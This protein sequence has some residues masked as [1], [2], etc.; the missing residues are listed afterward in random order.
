[1]S[2]FYT[3]LVCWKKTNKQKHTNSAFAAQGVMSGV[4][5]CVIAMG[6]ETMTNV[7]IGANIIDSYKAGRGQPSESKGIQ[8]KRPGV[9]FSQF[10]GAELL[11]AKYSLTREE[12]DKFAVESH[13]KATEATKAGKFKQEILPLQGKNK[14]G[15]VVVHDKDEG[16]RP[17]TNLESLSKLKTLDPNGI[18]TAA[19]AS[20]IADGAAALMI[21]NERGLKKFGLKPKAKI[22]QI[23]GAGSDPE[24]ML[25]GPIP[26]T[27]IAFKKSGLTMAQM[28]IYE[29]SFFF[30]QDDDMFGAKCKKKGKLT[31]ISR[32]GQRS[33]CACAGRVGK[34]SRCRL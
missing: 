30:L 20:Q 14:A 5:D 19:A 1:M 18:I 16:I 34:S 33:V 11:A 29:V 8:A 24:I 10:K 13:R 7:P 32:Q 9:Q 15:D 12:L 6:V 21:C 17:S 26:A 28:D 25:E 4:H 27:E 3:D 22:V 23:A 2:F 31:K